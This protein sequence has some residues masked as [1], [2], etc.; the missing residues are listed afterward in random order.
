M[1]FSFKKYQRVVV[2]N[3]LGQLN[4]PELL[5]EQKFNALCDAVE[6]ADVFLHGRY[7]RD[8]AKS[9][10]DTEAFVASHN[11]RYRNYS[12]LIYKDLSAKLLK[13]LNKPFTSSDKCAFV[14]NFGSEGDSIAFN[15]ETET[16]WEE[17]YFS[18]FES[19]EV[20]ERL[21]KEL[22]RFII[23]ISDVDR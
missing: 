22:E 20:C 7:A 2:E 14:W 19:E 9:D 18:T 17:G 3:N 23:L 4:L 11:P 16:L 6:E 13:I 21:R 1:K 12:S 10:A 15:F 5:G 8:L